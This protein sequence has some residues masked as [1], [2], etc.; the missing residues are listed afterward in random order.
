MEVGETLYVYRRKEWRR[1]LEEHFD[2]KEEIWLVLPRKQSGKPK[3][4]YNDSVEEALCFGWI[5]SIQKSLNEEAT[6]QRFSR[7]KPKSNWSQLNRERIRW[8]LQQK[9]VHL[10][11]VAECRRVAAEEFVFPED[12]LAALQKNKKAWENYQGLSEAYQRIRVAYIEAARKR[13]GEFEKR[14][15]NFI[16][17]TEEKKL[18]GYGGIEKYY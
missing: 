12:V 9:L 14:L 8:L 5:D 18:I 13:P 16:Q 17:K 10:S 3:L 11:L 7:R 2:K 15:R 6:V 1:W 4:K